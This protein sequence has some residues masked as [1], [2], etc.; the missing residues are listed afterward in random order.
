MSSILH[1][2][3]TPRVIL[4]LN[5]ISAAAILIHKF[6]YSEKELSLVTKICKWV[7]LVSCVLGGFWGVFTGIVLFK[8][9][10]E[11][12]FLKIATWLTWIY[13]ALA[14]GLARFIVNMI[15]HLV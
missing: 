1:F 4:W 7:A 11:E 12:N 10:V 14:I 2:F 3:M 15:G 6:V 13:V 5:L 9:P 8:H